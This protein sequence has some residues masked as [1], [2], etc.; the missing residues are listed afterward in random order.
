MAGFSTHIV[1]ANDI[2]PVTSHTTVPFRFPL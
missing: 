2:S 1:T